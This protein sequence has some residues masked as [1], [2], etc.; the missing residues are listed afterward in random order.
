MN[1]KSFKNDAGI[2]VN[3][4]LDRVE[5]VEEGLDGKAVVRFGAVGVRLGVPYG[6]FLPDVTASEFRQ[7]PLPPPPP[8]SSPENNNGGGQG[9]GENGGG[10]P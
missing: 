4:D 5:A 7:I 8:P 2:L 6:E 3:V 1:V 9:G 10:N